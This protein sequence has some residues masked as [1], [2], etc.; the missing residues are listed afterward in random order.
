MILLFLRAVP[1][2]EVNY[3]ISDFRQRVADSWPDAIDPA[4]AKAD[5]GFEP[6]FDLDAI[7]KTMIE[8]LSPKLK[9]KVSLA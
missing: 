8:K 4:V 5:F 6:Q 2:F 9:P 3:N 7:T 1:G